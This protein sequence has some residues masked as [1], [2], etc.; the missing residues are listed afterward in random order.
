MADTNIPATGGI[1]IAPPPGAPTDEVSM[2]LQPQLIAEQAAKARQNERQLEPLTYPQQTPQTESNGVVAAS[3]AV[4]E[5]KPVQAASGQL[6]KTFQM[7]KADPKSEF[8]AGS[9]SDSPT[10]GLPGTAPVPAARATSPLT[11][12]GGFGESEAEYFPLDGRELKTLVEQLLDELHARITNDLRFSVA[13]TYPRVSAKLQLIVEGEADDQAFM[14]ERVMVPHDK[15]P[16]DVAQAFAD[17]VSFVVRAQRREFDDK[18]D[19]ESP[20]DSLRD[21]LGLPKP[22]KHSVGTGVGR[23]MVDVEW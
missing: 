19:V 9:N 8:P 13:V 5:P 23:T 15:T 18:G 11:V 16:L 6:P 17:S 14:V 20:A 10:R 22:R 7:A 21:E 3:G 4:Q 1:G 2:P 12:I